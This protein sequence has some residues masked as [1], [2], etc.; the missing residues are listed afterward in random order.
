MELNGTRLR[1][2]RFELGLTLEELAKR[3]EM[4]FSNL[5]RLELGKHGAHPATARK[6]A[7]AYDLPMDE[8]VV[9]LMAEKAA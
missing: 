5:S 3:A 6:L 8:F 9:S 4:D 1:N 7:V 2:R